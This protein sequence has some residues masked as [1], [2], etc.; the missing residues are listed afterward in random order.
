MRIESQ[1]T[2][3]SARA[4]RLSR[5]SA[6]LT[7]RVFGVEEA[8]SFSEGIQ[9]PKVYF[10]NHTSHLDFLLLWSSLPEETRKNTVPVA[11]ADYWRENQIRRVIADDLFDAVLI[12]RKVVTRRNNPIQSILAA[13]DCGKSVIIFPEGG[14][15]GG[16]DIA[17]FKCGLYY[18]A[19]KRPG[20]E[21][22]PAYI[23]NANKA[24]PKGHAIPVP[25][26]CSVSF[27][28]SM[29][30]QVGESKQDFVKRARIS[31]ELCRAA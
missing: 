4:K 2:G 17:E 3:K 1:E 16:S 7:R 11:A 14:R 8:K 24:L 15:G 25:L 28:E 31:L 10:A 27:G 22:V 20:L 13:I 23:R 6:R 30:L 21:F 19:K 26:I 5:L 18:L 12:D 29:V 9:K